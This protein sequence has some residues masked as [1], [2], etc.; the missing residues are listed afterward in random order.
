[1]KIRALITAFLLLSFFSLFAQQTEI[2]TLSQTDYKKWHNTMTRKVSDSGD[3]VSIWLNYPHLGDTLKIISTNELRQFDIPDATNGSFVGK[4][5]Y[6]CLNNKGQLAILDLMGGIKYIDSVSVFT[7]LD[8]QTLVYRTLGEESRLVVMDLSGKVHVAISRCIYYSYSATA[9]AI[10]FVCETPEGQQ[11]GVID[12]KKYMSTIITPPNPCS[13]P[14]LVW[15]ENGDSFTFIVVFPEEKK[16]GLI[17]YYKYKNKRLQWFDPSNYKDFPQNAKLNGDGFNGLSISP[18]GKRIFC[19]LEKEKVIAGDPLVQIWNTFDKEL[20]PL[21]IHTNGG[22]NLAKMCMWEPNSN[23]F[24]QITS[25]EL[26]NLML[27]GTKTHAILFNKNEHQPQFNMNASRDYYIM[28]L[29]TGETKLFLKKQDG[30]NGNTFVSPGGK[31][32]TYY[33]EGHWWSYDITNGRHSNLTEKLPVSFKQEGDFAGTIPGYQIPGWL[34]DD[35]G[36]FIYDPY[37]VWCISPKEG[38]ARKITNGRKHKLRYRI[39]PQNDAQNAVGNY[40]GDYI[41][42]LYQDSEPLLFEI[43]G[44]MSGGFALWDKKTG[45]TPVV[46]NKNYCHHGLIIPDTKTVIYL[47]ENY[48]LPPALLSKRPSSPSKLLFQTNKQHYNYQWGKSEIVKYTALGKELQGAL[49]Y[50]AG[51]DPKQT[52]PMVVYIYEELAMEVNRYVNPGE[53]NGTGFNI[54]NLSS[55]GYFVLLPDISYV[56]GNPGK[57]ATQSVTNAVNAT[58]IK[59]PVDRSRMALVGHSFGGYEAAYIITQTDIFTTA[60]ASAG[61]QDFITGYLYLNMGTLIPNYWRYEYGQQRMGISL[62]DDYQKYLENSTIYNAE[63]INTPLLTFCGAEDHQVHSV[64][65]MNLHMALRRL[66][67]KNTHLVYRGEG[68]VLSKPESQEHC[69]RSVEQW[70][71]YYL[72]SEKKPEWL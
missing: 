3:W 17:G 32:I 37:D 52:Y 64:Q 4:R 44:I 42:G 6:V 67:K 36:V 48:N 43:Q 21:K 31:Y 19:Y 50:P 38:T 28:D 71:G 35:S 24:I 10:T 1:M 13:I 8:D 14:K 18:D 57:S 53:Y 51:Y 54:A 72:K 59:V 58:L 11:V 15:Q 39:I 22:E 16:S 40:D 45:L 63:K 41:P 23:R 70:L 33:R 9:K 25:N 68:H 5:W 29:K 27:N 26:P 56:I 47:E 69:T 30:S 34:S 46:Q 20:Y 7:C 55:Q 12:L 60:I 62:F 61:T 66:K 65:S 49:F 2:K